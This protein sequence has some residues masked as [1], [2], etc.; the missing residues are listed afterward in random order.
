[1]KKLGLT[2]LC[3]FSVHGVFAC[4]SSGSDPIFSSN[5]AGTTGSA[6]SSGTSA[7]K[8]AGGGMVSSGGSS[9]SAGTGGKGGTGGTGG[10]GGTGGSTGG[11]ATTGGT[12][13]TGGDQSGAGGAD[14][15]TA[16]DGTSGDAGAPAGGSSSGSGG[17]DQ[18]GAAG[19][20]TID[21]NSVHPNVN[22]S[23][24]TC[25]ADRCYCSGKDACFESAVASS[26]CQETVVCDA[27]AINPI[28][29]INHPGDGETRNPIDPIPFI[30]VASDPQ[31][32]AL[33]G[34]SLVWTSSELSSPIGTGTSFNATLPVGTHVITLTATDSDSNTG[35]DTITLTIE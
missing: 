19:Q 23:A 34:A 22:G 16:G 20:S 29:T 7:G 26:C 28:A 5:K 35:T 14:G 6:G 13:G 8:S 1:M 10:K 30:G 11:S 33:T 2:M 32:G 17:T 18:G 25:N 3:V 27:G 21:C 15:G 24:R 4:G 12:G 31:D 9:A